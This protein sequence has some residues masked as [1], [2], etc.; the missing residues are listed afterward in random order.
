[1]TNGNP[2]GVKPVICAVT[3]VALLVLVKGGVNWGEGVAA[4]GDVKIALGGVIFST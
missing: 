2:C 4:C 1:M 3:I